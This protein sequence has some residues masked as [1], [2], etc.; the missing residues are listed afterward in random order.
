[1]TAAVLL[2][3]A[4][5]AFAQ[6]IDEPAIAGVGDAFDAAELVPAASGALPPVLSGQEQGAR[7]SAASD[8]AAPA[9]GAREWF[10]AAPWAAWSRSTGDWSGA[11]T[12]LE[13]LGID[14]NGSLVSEWSR[15][16]EGSTGGDSAFRF[17]L[18]LN[19]TVDLALLAGLEGATVFADFQT[20]DTGVGDVYN[21][22]Y[23]AYSNIAIGGSI[24]QLSQLWWEQWL[25]DRA[26]RVKIGK[27]DANAEFA[28]LPAA[29]GFINSSAGFTPTIFAFPTYPNPAT[30][31]NLFVYPA[32]AVYVGFGLYD[33]ASAVDGVPT[34]SRGPATF[35]SDD[36]SDDWF[37][38]AE[39]G[40]A[41]EE[42]AHAGL[43]AGIGAW[44]H[45][46]DFTTFAGGSQ[47]G[48][49]GVYGIAQ[50]RLWNPRPWNPRPWSESA[51]AADADDDGLGLWLFGQYGLADDEVS[52]VRQHFGVGL[53]LAGTF[54]GREGDSCG[55]YL[56][57]V[58]FTDAPAAGFDASETALELFYDIEVTPWLHVK[59]DLQWYFDP[60][61]SSAAE[62]SLVGTLRC[63]ILF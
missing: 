57:V 43:R 35:F 28:F 48:T 7:S 23:V 46:G 31:A 4:P 1:M 24:T 37:L 41:L 6:S 39:A 30:A 58:D 25:L 17:L 16:L 42:G 47:D 13:D 11:R 56:S 5:C 62:D 55:V 63:T 33:G 60:S 59:P 32:D 50:A 20:A 45:T 15:F 9:E 22:G 2:A 14:F 49:G 3:S 51:G 36:A 40:I 18:D 8:A 44:W 12:A 27:V 10:G 38:I 34:G 61:G 29:G 54:A 52:D 26:V 53:S 21:G 19:A